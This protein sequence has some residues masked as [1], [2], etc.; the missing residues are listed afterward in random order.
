MLNTGVIFKV[1]DNGIGIAEENLNK[2]FTY[3]YTTKDNGHGFGL[4]S[5]HQYIS[6]MNGTLC[7]ESDG[8]E[9]GTT[10]IMEFPL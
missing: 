8:L 3:G 5:C 9:K 4:H 10:F 2:I 7:V 6:E 1:R